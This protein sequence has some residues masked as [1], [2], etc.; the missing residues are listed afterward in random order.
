MSKNFR[1]IFMTYIWYWGTLPN[2]RYLSEIFSLKRDVVWWKFH[3]NLFH[4]RDDWKY[5]TVGSRNCWCRIGEEPLSK[6]IMSQFTFVCKALNLNVLSG[7]LR[8]TIGKRYSNSQ[9]S[10]CYF[11]YTSILFIHFM[12]IYLRNVLLLNSVIVCLNR[13]D[14]KLLQIGVKLIHIAMPC[15][16][17]ITALYHEKSVWFI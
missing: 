8:Q 3:K 11:M 4:A 2:G 14:I 15:K 17:S 5:I 7:L 1:K 16:H 10:R 6:T 13:F 9:K 12:F